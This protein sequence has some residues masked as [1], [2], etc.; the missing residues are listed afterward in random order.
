[1]KKVKILFGLLTAMLLLNAAATAQCTQ[2]GA[3]AR[4]V[5]YTS[6]KDIIDIAAGSDDFTTLVTAV[7]A[8]GLVENL[9]GDGPFTVFAPVNEAFAKL[10]D[11]TVASL[12]EPANKAALTNVLT[13]HVAAGKFDSKAVV[14][15]I[16]AGN[17]KAELEMV[18]GGTLRATMRDGNVYLIDENYN[19]AK[20]TTV[21]LEASNGVI[22]VIETVVLPK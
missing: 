7:K 1:M 8:A 3:K 6:D 9:K 19:L 15:A 11:G 22:H 5:A 2:H 13:Y 20:V 12:L 4:T 17:G 10:P 14:E 18:N 16:K 21:D